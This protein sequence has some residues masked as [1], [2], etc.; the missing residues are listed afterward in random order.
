MPEDIL[1]L[2]RY[3]RTKQLIEE[4]ISLPEKRLSLLIR[5]VHSNGGSLSKKK[6]QK[7]FDDIL[8]E[9]LAW[10]EK[11]IRGCFEIDESTFSSD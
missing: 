5:L 8:D 6:R 7:L 11:V 4:Q 10:M 3:D 9:D 2:Q 1:L